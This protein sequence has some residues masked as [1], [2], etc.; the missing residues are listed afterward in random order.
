MSNLK[1]SSFLLLML[2]MLSFDFQNTDC[3]PNDSKPKMYDL[4]NPYSLQNLGR[5]KM[6]EFNERND[7]K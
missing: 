4:D 2:L 1:D 7:S 5:F 3:I 6:N